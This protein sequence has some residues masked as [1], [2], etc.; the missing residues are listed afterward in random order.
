MKGIKGK[1]TSVYFEIKGMLTVLAAA[2]TELRLGLSEMTP[3]ICSVRMKPTSRGGEKGGTI[4][5]V[6]STRTKK[7]S[8]RTNTDGSGWRL[9]IHTTSSIDRLAR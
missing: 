2:R 4:C 5:S 7:R 6:Y 1:I 8:E 9:A 3:W